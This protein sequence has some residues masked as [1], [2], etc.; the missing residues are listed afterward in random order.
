MQFE[1]T[2][3]RTFEARLEHMLFALD[4]RAQSV[5][6]DGTDS[7]FHYGVAGVMATIM[8]TNQLMSQVTDPDLMSLSILQ[9]EQILVDLIEGR[10]Q[11]NRTDAYQLALDILRGERR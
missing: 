1:G 8:G 11:D 4:R 2:T 7:P 9:L 3:N 6:D 10:P 5:P